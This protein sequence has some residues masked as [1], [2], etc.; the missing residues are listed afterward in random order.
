MEIFQQTSIDWAP[1]CPWYIILAWLALCLLA[2]GLSWRRF[3]H[4]MSLPRRLLLLFLRLLA[5]A[6]ATLLLLQP[7]INR[8]EPEPG[9]FRIAILADLSR[10][11]QVSDAVNEP[12]RLTQLHTLLQSDTIPQL[13]R[14]GEL[15]IWGFSD[16][17]QRLSGIPRMLTPLPGNTDLGEA[18]RRAAEGQPG[19]APLGAVLLF[20]DGRDTASNS[21]T[22]VAKQFKQQQ[23]PISC[24]GIGKLSPGLDT[25]VRF[26]IT[27][28]APVPRDHEFILPA[29]IESTF[30]GTET[31]TVELLENGQVIQS[32]ECAIEPGANTVE[33]SLRSPIAG[34][35]TYAVRLQAP[36]ADNR[37][38]NNLDFINVR[39]L[40][41]DRFSL[42]YLGGALDWEWRFLRIHAERN[43]Q[44]NLAAIIQTGSNNFFRS[45]LSE[46]QLEGLSAF[47]EQALFY[48]PFDGVLLDSRA[49]ARLSPAGRQALLAFCEHKGGGLL[50]LG[51]AAQFPPEFRPLLPFL[52]AEPALAS[53]SMRLQ[54]SSELIF[55]RDQSR[56]LSP[57]QGLPLPPGSELQ[58]C[59]RNKRGARTALSLGD[60]QDSLLS[61]QTYGAGR[62]AFLGLSET[63]KWRFMDHAGETVH[64]TFWNCLLVW[65]AE[66]H[67]P[68]LQPGNDGAKVAVDEPTS[69]SL[70]ILGSD[71]LPAADAL[72]SAVI[73]APDGSLSEVRLEPAWDQP[74]QYST[75]YLPPAAGEYRV[76][77]QVKLPEQSFTS[78]SMFLARQSGP[79]MADTDF[80]EELLRDIARISQGNYYTPRQFSQGIGHLPLSPRLPQRS[81]RR[82]LASSWLLFAA[83]TA[84]FLAEWAARRHLGLK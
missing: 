67:Q 27:T 78:E 34:F 52:Q 1:V 23:V 65:L 24:V 81:S 46:K 61:A 68:Q 73:T 64:Q 8:S 54:T 6:L 38:D 79:E 59:R 30:P 29:S 33:F 26:A 83:I 22:A 2:A 57:A 63:W 3:R 66:Q 77:Y 19:A 37:L 21:A 12:N 71:F 11:L 16:Q 69:V 62:S 41:P 82:P 56:I 20:S 80:N 49:A 70:E 75:Q 74:G 17:L 4:N 25:K 47:P 10:S 51:A 5:L 55:S 35:R 45:G 42:L 40:E 48:A 60:S 9:A 72:A 31:L 58:V 76:H 28:L 18:L 7:V 43:E 84:A 32:W 39:I 53:S 36:A 14:Q 13:A 50:L 15:E 44:L